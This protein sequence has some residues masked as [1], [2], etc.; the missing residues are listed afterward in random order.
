MCIVIVYNLILN[1]IFRIYFIIQRHTN[2]RADVMTRH[3]KQHLIFQ[4]K[5]NMQQPVPSSEL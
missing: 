2:S 3:Q 4:K 1:C 5:I